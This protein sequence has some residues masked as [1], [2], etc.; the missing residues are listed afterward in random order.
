MS[1]ITTGQETASAGGG[2]TPPPGRSRG[3]P[4]RWLAPLLASV[5]L[6]ASAGVA[7]FTWMRAHSAPVQ[8]TSLSAIR[9]SGIPADVPTHL[10][11]FM[12][13]QPEKAVTAPNFTLTDQRGRRMSLR[14]F[15]GRPVVLTFF[16]PHCHTECPLVSQEFV[17][18]EHDLTHADTGV[19]YLAVNVNRHALSVATVLAFSKEHGLNAIPTWHFLTGSLRTLRHIWREYGIEVATRI[20]HGNWTVVHTSILF[21]I[22]PD[23]KERFVAASNADYRSTPTHR[24]YLP[25]LTLTAWG[26]GIAL[27]ARSL[28]R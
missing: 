15:R 18:A 21:F 13:L 22:S 20:V 24:A 2:H 5:V 6:A 11:N 26:H 1:Q 3:Q 12:G 14:S 8:Q 4:H 16:D 17:D 10:A 19:V 7:L 25:A 9:V 28:A 27:V 23:G